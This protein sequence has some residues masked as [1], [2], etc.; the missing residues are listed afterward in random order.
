MKILK[1]SANIKQELL[2]IK[3]QSKT[4]YFNHK[5]MWN[6]A[7]GFD[8]ETSSFYNQN[9]EKTAIM[10]EW[11]FIIEELIVYGRT[12]EE[13]IKLTDILID[14]FEL[15]TE[16]QLFIGVHNL[17]YEM[18]F[19]YKRFTWKKVFCVNNRKPVFALTTTGLLFRCTY[20]L[21][22]LSL[23]SL[24]KEIGTVEKLKGQ[25]DYDV[26]R[27]SKT[28]LTE[29]E[30]QYC[31][32]DV[33]I[34]RDFIRAEIE[35]NR[36][37]VRIPLTKTGYVRRYCRE[38]C[39]G[40]RATTRR[41]RAIEANTPS[42]RKY[43][44]L[45]ANTDLSVDEYRQ[46]RDAFSGGFTHASAIRA[47]R[48]Y[49]NMESLD[50]TS[51]YPFEMVVNKYPIGKAHLI[52]VRTVERLEEICKT[53]CCIFDVMFIGLEPSII[54]EHYIPRYKC[55][56]IENGQFD[57]GR[58][59]SAD[60]LTI[61]ITNVDWEII[62]TAYTWK[63]IGIA[64]CRVYAK[65]Y[66]PRPF[67]LSILKLYEDKTKLKGLTGATEEETIDILK[68]YQLSKGMLNSCYGMT[69][70]DVCKDIYTV[71]EDEWICEKTDVNKAIE[72]YNKSRKRFLMYQTSAFVTSY[73]RKS[74]WDGIHIFKTD[75]VYTDT[76]S[77]KVLNYEKHAAEIEECNKRCIE[78][79][80]AAAEFQN[81]PLEMFMPKTLN[82]T[83]KPLGVW[84][85]E[86]KGNPY[87]R[88][89]TIGAKRYFYEDNDGYHLTCAGV[90]KRDGR[91]YICS[92]DGDPFDNFR[93]GL[94]IPAGSS[95][96]LTHTYIDDV[97]EGVVK[98]YLGNY[99]EYKELSCVHLEPAE[100][101]LSMDAEYIK[102]LQGI[103]RTEEML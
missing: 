12:W 6:I 74:L 29:D 13:F 17:A 101:N 3:N 5:R 33:I 76:D 84:E 22:G 46:I 55:H 50:R 40:G 30:L 52:D 87:K 97:R 43:K 26:I 82:G 91:D 75:L 31:F 61:T 10:Y 9:D 25:L 53:F 89:K 93:D 7:A 27:H 47:N 11:T 98:D 37:I 20:L 90:D 23:D 99:G 102:L 1:Y 38:N 85:W 44:R 4:K 28:P 41:D 14:V 79:L 21:S 73:A 95:G 45:I 34:V 16:K 70:M 103:I 88:F 15:S 18:G 39:I 57:N 48:V 69:A 56:N 42:I 54:Y 2:S 66:L 64:N 83:E 32:N 72:S 58:V 86:T 60:K 96:K 68:R 67:V 35:K 63:H 92:L 24:A 65:A 100:Y 80:K 8:I 78:K 94:H 51:A 19:I 77:L 62:K 36:N 81:I 59:M 49:D 71:K